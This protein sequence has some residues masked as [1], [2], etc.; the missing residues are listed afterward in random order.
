MEFKHFGSLFEKMYSSQIFKNP[1]CKY[2][3]DH[4]AEKAD[5]SFCDFWDSDEIKHE[6]LGNSAVII[7]SVDAY[8]IFNQMEQEKYIKVKRDL[9]GN[10]LL[11]TQSHV[12]NAKK[13]LLRNHPYYRIFYAITSFIFTFKIYRL[14]G[15]KI[16]NLFSVAWW[17]ISGKT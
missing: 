15:K 3:K 16:Y 14:F 5:I 6:T 9:E 13:S 10:D 17:R 2:C 1:A 7:R 4:F 11:N 8:N 12:V